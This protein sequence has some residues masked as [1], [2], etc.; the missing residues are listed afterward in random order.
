MPIAAPTGVSASV[1]TA[2]GSVV[3]GWTDAANNNAGYT[4][5]QVLDLANGVLGGSTA[6][7]STL[8]ISDLN[9]IVD[10]INKNYDNGT[11]NSGYC[12]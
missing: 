8:T 7:P 11:T 2:S 9:A 3:L 12:G 6:L 10:S 1:G 5:Q 4:V